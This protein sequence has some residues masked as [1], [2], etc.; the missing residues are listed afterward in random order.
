[1]QNILLTF[2][3]LF[4]ALL[5]PCSLADRS[6][7]RPNKQWKTRGGHK[8]RTEERRQLHDVFGNHGKSSGGGGEGRG[9]FGSGKGGKGGSF[10]RSDG[11]SAGKGGHFHT[12]GRTD[13]YGMNDMTGV[14]NINYAQQGPSTAIYSSMAYTTQT[15]ELAFANKCEAAEAGAEYKTSSFIP[16]YY[17]YEV[18]TS[19][20]RNALEI[21]DI[22]D[23]ACQHFLAVWMVDCDTY[24]VVNANGGNRQRNLLQSKVSPKLHRNLQVSLAPI[25]GVGVGD[26]DTVLG[27]GGTSVD[28]CTTLVSSA[29]LGQA[30]YKVIGSLLVYLED[31]MMVTPSDVQMLALETLTVGMNY[32][33]TD[34][35]QLDQDIFEMQ[36]IQ[37]YGTPP[38]DVL[39]ANWAVNQ[40]EWDTSS[41]PTAG[42][43]E[44][45]SLGM[46]EGKEETVAPSE[47]RTGRSGG[48]KFGIAFAT[49][50]C[51]TI[52]AFVA[53]YVY[54]NREDLLHSDGS[55][56]A[57]TK[58][59][60][61]NQTK[62]F[63]LDEE[64]VVSKQYD[65]KKARTKVEDTASHGE[66]NVTFR[67]FS[68]GS[69]DANSVSTRPLSPE[70]ETPSAPTV[71]MSEDSDRPYMIEASNIITPRS[72]IVTP[73]SERNADCRSTISD[74]STPMM[75]IEL[76]PTPSD[77]HE[78]QTPIDR[79]PIRINL[80]KDTIRSGSSHKRQQR[81][82]PRESPQPSPRAS[83]YVSPNRSYQVEDT[84]EL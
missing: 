48:A 2:L 7:Q 76:K 40:R 46:N 82:P 5:L 47:V 15:S 55:P 75:R 74:V 68:S 57:K 22:I 65:P 61:K 21:A 10:G 11:R 26:W 16:V 33:T 32:G 8:R 19:S 49:L 72:D 71:A 81:A 3:F 78:Q 50:L 24:P 79:Q 25:A 59:T 14:N 34:F 23:K 56:Q 6:R 77:H 52:A 37:G 42:N 35:T 31:G 1:M 36:F 41:N 17:Q 54:K 38:D 28:Q 70:P 69:P 58:K 27:L 66:V 51:I 39:D 73:R 18:V 53:V 60:G 45:S 30:C 63:N 64:S 29:A 44:M 9:I 4:A 20:S 13:T 83:E 12:Y 67:S 80:S 62:H 43:L 84:V